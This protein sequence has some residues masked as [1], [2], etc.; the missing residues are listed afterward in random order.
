MNIDNNNI[1]HWLQQS[2]TLGNAKLNELDWLEMQHLLEEKN[3]RK[4]LF[5]YWLIGGLFAVFLLGVLYWVISSNI[6]SKRTV[7]ISNKKVKDA[8]KNN[9]FIL[10]NLTSADT[11][12][13]PKKATILQPV[14]V[15]NKKMI[16]A[17]PR[18]SKQVSNNFKN[19][20]LYVDTLQNITNYESISNEKNVH[21]NIVAEG[22]NKTFAVEKT[23]P[24]FND[25]IESKTPDT[26]CCLKAQIPVQKV[27]DNKNSWW[28]Q[29]TV[30]AGNYPLNNNIGIAL[31]KNTLLKNN[32]SLLYGLGF[33]Y[34]WN[35]NKML[36]ENYKFISTIP[37]TTRI[38]VNK[39]QTNFTIT[40]QL[41]VQ[42][43]ASI[44]KE[45]KKFII[46]IPFQYQY[47]FSSQLKKVSIVDTLE[48]VAANFVGLQLSN[49]FNNELFNKQH[50]VHMGLQLGYFLNKNVQF[51]F[52][53]VQPLIVSEVKQVNTI[54]TREVQLFIRKKISAATNQKSAKKRLIKE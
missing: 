50:I 13:T 8:K 30:A 2:A 15:K 38:R 51:G 28:L 37:G 6:D 44:N 32:W 24:I 48:I 43:N 9:I 34:G 22:N 23:I 7:A 5:W 16:I 33:I 52:S 10:E 3:K 39:K 12:K 40:N 4:P 21:E 49:D 31:T 54:S 14:L 41:S 53:I 18:F 29:A 17:N 36:H 27:N 1:Q 47:S 26:L 25:V 19:E 45:W 35:N 11:K 46:A 20:K 42:V